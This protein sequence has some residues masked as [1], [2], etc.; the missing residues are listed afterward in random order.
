MTDSLKSAFEKARTDEK[1]KDAID[2]K[3]IVCFNYKC[4]CLKGEKMTPLRPLLTDQP[5]DDGS[6]V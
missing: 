3:C 1:D 5:W 4:T 6:G 2:R